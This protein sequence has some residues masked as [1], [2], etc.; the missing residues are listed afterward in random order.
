MKIFDIIR[1]IKENCLVFQEAIDLGYS[2]TIY[3][4]LDGYKLILEQF[5][6]SSTEGGLLAASQDMQ[7]IV[8]YSVARDCHILSAIIKADSDSSSAAAFIDIYLPDDI[9]SQQ[10]DE[11]E[12]VNDRQEKNGFL[13]RRKYEI[14]EKKIEEKKIRRFSISAP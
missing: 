3:P 7:N 4:T 10:E 12:T 1:D 14:G 9:W 8:Q 11:S 5:Y 2:V 6:N 13:S